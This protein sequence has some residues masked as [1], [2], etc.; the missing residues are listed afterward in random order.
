VTVTAIYK[1]GSSEVITDG[2]TVSGYDAK[3]LGK[4][5]VTVTYRGVTATFEVNVI[6]ILIIGD[7]NGDGQVNIRDASQIQKYI[8]GVVEFDDE[9]LAVA[10]TNGDGEI[11]IR[12]ATQIQKFL[13]GLIPSLG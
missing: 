12:D 13:L 6:P 7:V 8:L 1:D 5:T 3:T 2:Y 9:Q 4:Q 10:D 11:N